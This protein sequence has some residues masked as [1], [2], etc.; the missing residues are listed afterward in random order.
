MFPLALLESHSQSTTTTTRTIWKI[1]EPHSPQLVARGPAQRTIFG[2][3]GCNVHGYPS[4]G[5]VFVKEADVLDLLR[6]SLSRSQACERSVDP[7]EEDEFCA[8][9]RLQRLGAK[10]WI[11]KQDWVNATLGVRDWT[12]EE[13]EVVVYIWPAEGAGMWVLRYE[14]EA[15]VPEDFGRLRLAL[16]MKERIATMRKYGAEFAADVSSVPELRGLSWE[17]EW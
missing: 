1:L 17:S 9:P 6:L 10:W 13:A 16:S 3:E 14:G 15:D 5:A 2:S 8:S 4:S 12:Q 7:N 11:S